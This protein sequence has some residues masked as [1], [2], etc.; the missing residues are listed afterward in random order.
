[1]LWLA[2]MFLPALAI[3][4]S[5]V[6]ADGWLPVMGVQIV[7]VMFIGV[8][9]LSRRRLSYL[10]RASTVVAAM[11]IIGIGAYLT[12]GGPSGL[13]FFVSASIMVAVFWG[14]RAG[15]ASI[16]FSVILVAAVFLAFSYGIIRVPVVSL[17]GLIATNAAG[18]IIASVGPLI[19]ISRF[20][21]YLDQG[22]LRAEARAERTQTLMAATL[23][24]SP[25]AIATMDTD[26]RVLLWNRAAERI[27]GYTSEEIIGHVNPLVEEE[28]GAL[29]ERVTKAML[30]GEVVRDV[31]TRR[32]RKDGK[33]VDIKLSSAAIYDGGRLSAFMT[34]HEDV[35]EQTAALQREVEE[36]HSHELAMRET[37]QRLQAVV[38]TSVHGMV[39]IDGDGTVSMFNPA[40]ERLFGYRADEV[41]GRNVKL[42]MPAPFHDEHDTYLQNYRRT[43]ERKIIGIGREVVGVRKDGTTFPMDLAVGEAR[44]GDAPIYVGVIVDLTERKRAD[45][46]LR[47]WGDAFEKA[48]FGIA[49]DDAA[50]NTFRLVNTAMAQLHGS[51]VDEMQGMPILA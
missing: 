42:L 36:R 5:R 32:R 13:V 14:E 6:F 22:R 29:S 9:A 18:A 21:A 12:Q 39:I 2:W 34:I 17:H 19:A 15:V 28:D 27:Y 4:L 10:A 31:P 20:R 40:A 41:L 48:A 30:A 24:G 16:A 8:V 1:M 7:L 26:R 50:T 33:L 37:N 44:Q 43:G 11:F 51:T 46:A 23:D 38:D 35:T 49:I 25:V 47:L 45:A 3:S